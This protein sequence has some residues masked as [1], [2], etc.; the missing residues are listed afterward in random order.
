MLGNW[1]KLGQLFIALE[2]WISKIFLALIVILVFIAALTRFL[3]SPI[4]WSVDIAQAIF[5]WEVYLGANQALR[6]SRHIGVSLF[7]DRLPRKAKLIVM[8]LHS[9]LICV[10]LGTTIYNGIL[11]SIINAGRI[12]QD[13]PISY[14]FITM[15]VPVGSLL[16]IITLLGQ[17]IKKLSELGSISKSE[18][19]MAG[20][21]EFEESEK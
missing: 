2:E 5:I 16:M 1:T 11:I 10:F 6:K 13:I 15:A 18:S 12:I 14:S 7:L 8:V 21:P 4:N 3:G 9:T 19:N 20:S 17:T